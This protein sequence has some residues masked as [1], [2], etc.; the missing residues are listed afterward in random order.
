MM[1]AV[2]LYSTRPLIYSLGNAD[3]SPFLF[4]AVI[5]FAILFACI[6]FLVLRYPVFLFDREILKI[7][8]VNWRQRAI[9]LAS[10]SAFDYALFAWSINYIDVSV[11]TILFETWPFLMV[12]ITAWL[13]K[14]HNRYRKIT[15]GVI[16]PLIL[17][18]TGFAFVILSQ[19]DNSDAVIDS[20]NRA[21]LFWSFIA[22]FGALLTAC[23]SPYTLK[24]GADMVKKTNQKNDTGQ[25]FFFIIVGF[26]ITRLLGGF[27]SGIL[28][29]VRGETINVDQ[30]TIAIGCGVFI[31]GIASMLLRR[32]NM[33]TS[34]LGVNALL[35]STP[36]FALIWL[37][38]SSLISVPRTDYLVIGTVA[39]IVAN[40]LVN[41]EASIRTA[42]KALVISL[43]VFGA[44]VYLVDGELVDSEAY[45]GTV[46]VV[47]TMYILLVAF[48]LDRIVGRTRH[49]EELS[50][51]V[52]EKLSEFI[53]LAKARIASGNALT[54]SAMTKKQ[55]ADLADANED[56]KQA[57]TARETL[58]KLDNLTANSDLPG[59]YETMKQNFSVMRKNA[60]KDKEFDRVAQ[61][62]A[63]ENNTD[64]FAHSKQQ[65]RN[66][67]ELMALGILGIVAIVVLL[68]GIP[69]EVNR[70]TVFMVDMVAILVSA[71]V[72]FL[73]FN[74]IDLEVDREFPMMGE[75]AFNRVKHGEEKTFFGV[76]FRTEKGRDRAFERALS[77]IV[78]SV[79]IGTYA[80]F[81]WL[82]V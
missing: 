46:G 43:W 54:K 65:G 49:E 11:A 68:F 28:G 13:F 30:I 81:L 2:I 57:A 4:N 62:Y 50:L 22:V 1:V 56:Y 80:Y 69:D 18:F 79:I 9:F 45:L 25:E 41:F 82:P 75:V 33:V 74:L 24:W 48:R 38:L 67:G 36:I 72:V 42:Y 6:V 73:F 51:D 3:S 16:L 76:T 40:L 37:E 63:L 60:L 53:F 26:L 70:A 52:A 27:V 61:I 34:N 44:M 47:I 39:I 15:F 59:S 29:G 55:N 77:I 17:G 21:T 31:T 64:K 58:Q 71:T 32:A 20:F 7:I 12:F 5:N 8:L 19:S 14:G 78:C 35:Y 23:S 66:F 10:L